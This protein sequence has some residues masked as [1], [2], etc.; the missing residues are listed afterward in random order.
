MES[1]FKKKKDSLYLQH[2]A[3]RHHPHSIHRACNKRR[4]GAPQTDGHGCAKTYT[5]II[6]HKR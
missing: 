2:I 1:C 6:A 4:C 3:K 5:T